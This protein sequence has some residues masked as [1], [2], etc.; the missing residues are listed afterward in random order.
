MLRSFGT[1]R[2]AEILLCTLGG[3]A[4][5]ATAPADAVYRNGHIYTA[6]AADHIRE[7]VAIR[8]GRLAYVGT[9]A[10]VAG[11]IGPKTRVVDLH[12]RFAMPGLVDAHMHPLEGGSALLTCNLEYLRL[13]VP[14][15]QARIRNCLEKDSKHEPDGWLVV[16]GWFQQAMQPAGVELSRAT[17]DALS[18]RRPI[19]V[20]DSFGHTVLANARALQLA[21][22]TRATK[23][24]PGGEI[25]HDANGEPT[26]LLEDAAFEPMEE[27]RPPQTPD[28]NRD[29]ARAA[30]AAFARQGVTTVFDADSE[31]G[32]QLGV[33]AAFATIE[34]AGALTARVHFAP[35]LAPTDIADPA[36]AI[37]RV[38]EFRRRYD[39]KPAGAAPRLTVR[40][41]KLY[42]DGVIS[43]PAFSGTLLEPYLVNAGTAAV[44]RWV[45]GPSRGPDPYYPPA[46]LAE[47]LTRLARAGIDPHM[48]ADGDGA[49]HAAL[50]GIEAMRKAVPNTDIRPGIAHD[51]MVAPADYPRFRALGTFPVVS[52]QWE[53]PAPDTVEQ[54][55]D[56]IG[57]DRWAIAEPA[58]LLLA[59]G[60]PVAFGSDW[61]V[62]PL[63]EWFALKVAVTRENAPA[64][65]YTGRL[66]TDPGLK[67]VDAL[68]AIT[69][70]AAAALHDDARIGSLEQDKF[71]DLIVL[72]RNP[73]EIPPAA[74]ADVKVLET[75]IGGKVVYR[76]P[77]PLTR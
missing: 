18:T 68:R 48:H 19:R 34:R 45:P 75:V 12:G 66:G 71:A 42:I 70:V 44:P 1:A 69:I 5:A 16:N 13:T 49:V 64:S 10:G 56:Y 26:G 43:G 9:N 27:L 53:K 28:E 31:S 33:L 41:A 17:L 58:G 63:D 55:R 46:A 59:A 6:D 40:N 52:F 22:I 39:Q 47:L 74:I 4:S 20:R 21:G 54:L 61:P 35:H 30:L 76:A 23:N 67:P 14:E 65:G 2:F 73:L 24:P 29:A 62:D 7:A 51:E 36:A 77:G 72:D 8:A 57:A 15:F 25:H 38:L 60:A 11:Y 32:S 50:D 3:A 37:R